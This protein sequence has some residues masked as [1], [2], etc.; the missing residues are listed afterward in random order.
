MYA[1]VGCTMNNNDDEEEEVDDM[2]I[3]HSYSIYR[4]SSCFKCTSLWLVNGV[5]LPDLDTFTL[6]TFK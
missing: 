4:T 6:T 2:Q 5:M 3:V 1:S